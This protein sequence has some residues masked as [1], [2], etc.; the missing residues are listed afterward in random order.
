M[1]SIWII[2][3]MHEEIVSIKNDMNSL[4]TQ[5]IGN[6]SFYLWNWNNNDIVLVQSGI[7]KVNAAIT[8][9]LLIQYFKPDFILFSGVAGATDPTLNIGDIVISTDLIQHDFNLTEFGYKKGQ[10]PGTKQQAL[11]ASPE[12]LEK[13]KK[14]TFNQ[15][16]LHFGR[17]ISGDQFI[18]TRKEKIH[19]GKEF[20]ALC[21]DMESAAVA[22][23]CYNFNMPFLIIR[24]ISDTVSDKSKMEFETFL[25]IAARNSKKIITEILK[26]S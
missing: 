22:Q 10:L 6:L 19:L 17:I 18:S 26:K 5:T 21:V 24:S 8:A 12:L 1:M 14:L 23:V 9:T 11:P 3:A 25:P 4:T 13:T 20:N 2:G 16:S 15:T 7:G